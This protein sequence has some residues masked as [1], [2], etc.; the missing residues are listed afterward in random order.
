VASEQHV[1]SQRLQRPLQVPARGTVGPPPEAE[2]ALPDVGLEHRGASTLALMAPA[3]A[4]GSPM[5]GPWWKRTGPAR[6]PCPFPCPLISALH[7]VDVLDRDGAAVAE[8]DDDNSQT[9]GGLAGR[10]R[11]HKEREHLTD[12]V[13]HE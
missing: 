3:S 7:H 11:Q 13:A 1:A 9:D 12:E 2:L 8:V 4:G 6:A 5:T 10:H